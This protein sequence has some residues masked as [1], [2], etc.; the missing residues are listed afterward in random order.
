MAR[1]GDFNA[2][3]ADNIRPDVRK[4]SRKGKNSKRNEEVM[5]EPMPS[6]VLTYQSLPATE[7]SD[8]ERGE[9]SVDV[10][11]GME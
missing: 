6:D 10:M 5:I 3:N 4:K 2:T 9:E 1:Q 8:D 7:V 11:P